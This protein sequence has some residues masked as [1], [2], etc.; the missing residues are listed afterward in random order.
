MKQCPVSDI[1][2]STDEE[3]AG[4][5][6]HQILDSKT[7]L[8]IRRSDENNTPLGDIHF[9]NHLMKEYHDSIITFKLKD[10]CN[11]EADLISNLCEAQNHPYIYNVH[12]LEFNHLALDFEG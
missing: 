5:E 4:Y 2:F 1:T 11:I 8:F 9:S 12:F 7:N 10:V 6:K 3:M